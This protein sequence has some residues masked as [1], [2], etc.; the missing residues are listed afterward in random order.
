[1]IVPL[2]RWVLREACAHA[3]R[4]QQRRDA[5][6]SIAVNISALEFRQKRFVDGVRSAL[7]DTGLSPHLLQLE[8][9][10]SILMRDAD[11]STAILRELKDLGI[12]LA[13]DDF[14]TGYSS[15]SYL[16]HFPIDILKIDRSFVSDIIDPSD[17]GVIVSAVIGM[18]RS[19]KKRVV[20]EGVEHQTQVDF[21]RTRNCDD[22][23][24]Y[25]FSRPLSAAQFTVMLHQGISR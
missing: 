5:P 3:A 8:L 9:T 2:G 10:E 22:V 20:A 19:L 15:L 11:A 4:W 24:G 13:I 17:E 7:I 25:L 21:L 18:A 14:G 1:M 6:L 16:K 12:R 23:Q